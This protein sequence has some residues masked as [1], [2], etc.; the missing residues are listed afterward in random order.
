MKEIN[1][2]LQRYSVAIFSTLTI[3][4]SFAAYLL[5]LP[6]QAL[7]FVLI[8][9]PAVLAVLLA[10]M[11]GGASGVRAL[12][13]G[14]TRW[15][16]SL[17]WL[18]IVIAAPF[19]MR[20][21]ISLI[22]L[23]LGLIPSIQLRPLTPAEAV[24]LVVIFI[25]GAI[26]EELGWRGYVLPRLLRS[27][28]PLVAGLIIGVLWGAVHLVLHLP[29]MPNE[30]LSGIL[31]M[32]QLIGLSILLTWVFVLGGNNILLTS[33]FHVAQSFFVIINHGVSISQQA[34]LMAVVFMAAGLIVA[35]A[36]RSMLASSSPARGQ[37]TIRPKEV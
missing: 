32:L 35:F 25:I 1:S 29:D 28:P 13:G 26:P 8:L 31:T 9:I 33:L 7:P 27:Y 6:R 5:P 14:L 4:L 30:G 15:R 22:A 2:I 24:L 19:A 36:S 12:L 20:L 21:A 16:V 3:L 34:W 10:G 23:L 11:T 18:L 17:R 37:Y